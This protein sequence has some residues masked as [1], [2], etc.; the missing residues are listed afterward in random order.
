V[1][2]ARSLW[3]KSLVDYSVNNGCIILRLLKL[4]YEK[5]GCRYIEHHEINQY[6]VLHFRT[7]H[8]KSIIQKIGIKAAIMKIIFI[9]ILSSLTL[10]GCATTSQYKAKL[11]TLVGQPEADLL[12]KWGKPTGRYKDENGDEV[13]AYIRTREFIMP[14]TPSYAISTSSYSGWGSMGGVSS[15]LQTSSTAIAGGTI[16]LNC[17]T[18]FI[19]KNGVVNSSTFKGN[20]CTSRN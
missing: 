16:Q 3:C 12:E 9:G 2:S 4:I 19:M 17:M 10:I 15:Q 5:Y 1:N 18:K 20:G 6:Y 14:S 13:I 8:M 7:F 11:D